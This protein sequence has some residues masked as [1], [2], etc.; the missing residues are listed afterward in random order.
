MSTKYQF[1]HYS[2]YKDKTVLFHIIISFFYSQKAQNN[3]VNGMP[4]HPFAL[5]TKMEF[6]RGF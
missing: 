3:D 2:D 1:I 4:F 5:M 6:N